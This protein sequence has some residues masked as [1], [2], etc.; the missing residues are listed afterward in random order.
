M[1]ELEVQADYVNY[2]FHVWADGE[3]VKTGLSVEIQKA[4]MKR[5]VADCT[6]M[7]RQSLRAQLSDVPP[8]LESIMPEP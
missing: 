6:E 5:V 3:L 7:F 1:P 8:G 2:Q 4:L